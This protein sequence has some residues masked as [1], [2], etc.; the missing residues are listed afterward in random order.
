MSSPAPG[1][2]PCQVLLDFDGTF[3]VPNVAIL[4]VGEFGVDG[5]RVA[6][7]VDEDLHAGRITLREAWRK[8]VALLPAARMGEMTDYV[9]RNVPLRQGAREFV[10]LLVRHRVPV[11]LVSGGLDF[12]IRTVLEREGLDLPVFADGLEVHPSGGALGVIHPHGHATCMLCGICKAQVVRDHSEPGLPA[13]FLG[14]GGTD[15]YAAEVADVVFARH[16]LKAYC[17]REGIPHIA[18]ENFPEVTERMA[19]WLEGRERVPRRG[20]TGLAHSPCPI[21]NGTVP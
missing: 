19:P 1:P 20:H 8:E 4:L 11:A 16:R 6:K 18:F 15:R 3:V 5:V 9:R 2:A 14:D 17:E 21:S 13:V 10:D 12:Y 7:E